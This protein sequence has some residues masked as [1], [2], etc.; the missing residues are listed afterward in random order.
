M[1]LELFRDGK[2]LNARDNASELGPPRPEAQGCF[3]AQSVDENGVRDRDTAESIR[4]VKDGGR[5]AG[6]RIRFNVNV[7]QLVQRLRLFVDR[8]RESPVQTNAQ[9]RR[10][11]RIVPLARTPAALETET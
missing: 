9:R 4:L 1:I 3:E 6:E 10:H 8:V 5:L 11:K 7:Q 2:R